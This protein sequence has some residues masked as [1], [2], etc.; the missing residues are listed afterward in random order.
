LLAFLDQEIKGFE[1]DAASASRLVDVGAAPRPSFLDTRKLAAWM[2]VA[3]V[4]F[5]LDETLTKG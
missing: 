4:L 5:N 1:N 3:N 2:M